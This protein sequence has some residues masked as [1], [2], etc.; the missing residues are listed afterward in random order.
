MK[1]YI[2]K[3]RHKQ[4]A[5]KLD[6]QVHDAILV[7]RC[8]LTLLPDIFKN[9]NFPKDMEKP[10]FKLKE[11][12]KVKLPI[13]NYECPTLDNATSIQIKGIKRVYTQA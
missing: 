2:D 8:L 11:L 7:E 10:S 9:P 13:T 6:I 3:E 4:V 1:P 5:K 12:R